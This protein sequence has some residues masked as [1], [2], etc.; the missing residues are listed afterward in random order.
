[1][2]SEMVANNYFL[3]SHL[4]TLAVHQYLSARI[5]DY[6]Y[7][8]DFGGVFYIFLRGVDPIRPEYGVFRDCPSEALV[9][10]MVQTLI[11]Q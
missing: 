11:R 7:G 6:N 10:D 1:M 3:Q 4:Y 5:P 8:R 9:S 2:F